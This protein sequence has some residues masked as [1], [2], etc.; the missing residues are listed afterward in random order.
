MWLPSVS[1]EASPTADYAD[2]AGFKHKKIEFL[3]EGCIWTLILTGDWKVPRTRRQE[4]L[5]YIANCPA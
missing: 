1:L 4:C 5:R 2:W 3:A